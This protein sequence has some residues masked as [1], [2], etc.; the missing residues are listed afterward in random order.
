[1]KQKGKVLKD[2]L[3]CPCDRAASTAITIYDNN[4]HCFACGKNWPDEQACYNGETMTQV[5]TSAPLSTVKSLQQVP[6]RA[7]SVSALIKYGVQCEFDENNEMIGVRYPGWVKG[8]YKR[9]DLRKK[10][11]RWINHPGPGLIGKDKFSAGS[12]MAITITEGEEDMLSVYEMLGSKYPVV[13][14]QGVA[15]AIQD[16]KTD[17]DYLNAFDK[18]YLCLD[19]DVPGKKAV[20]QISSMFPY[21]KIYVVDKTKYKDANEYHVNGATAEYVKVWWAAKRHDPEN[22]VSSF[23]DLKKEFFKP[24]KHSIATFPFSELQSATRGIRTG[25]TYL[26]KALEG[27]GKTEFIGAIEYHVLTTTDVPIGIIHLEEDIQRSSLRMVNYDIKVPVHLEGATTLTQDELFEHYKKLVK[28]DER[29]HYYK[30]GKNDT[31]TT[32][33]LN[34]VRFMVASAGCKVVFFD[35]ITRLATSFRLDDERKELD[36]VSTKLSEMAEEL[37]F[38][39]IMI[40][41]VNADGDTRG[42]KNISKEAWTVINLYRDRVEDDPILRNTTNLVIEKN[43]HA[44]TTGPAGAVFFNPETFTLSDDIPRISVPTAE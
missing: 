43:R 40:S 10:D 36:F 44:S 32:H 3:P 2:H 42:S 33:F 24:I 13:S 35:H 25:E 19:N 22:I 1:M 4:V 8:S 20:E 31:D 23:D 9:R 5:N 21:S 17:Y 26:V 38:A 39:L 30:K 37:D 27:I 41:H 29:V 34:A 7:H 11:F 28:H 16:C 12:A 6:Y 15:S 14:L 18:I